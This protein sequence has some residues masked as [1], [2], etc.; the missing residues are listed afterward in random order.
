MALYVLAFTDSD[1]GTWTSAGRRFQTV[2][3]GAVYAVCERRSAVP[4]L[5]DDALRAQHQAVIEIADRS[6]A[7]L[8]ARFGALIDERELV[9]WTRDHETELRRGLDDVRDRVQMTLRIVGRQARPSS[10][11]ATITSGRAYLESRRRAME[12]ELAPAVRELLDK[13]R[14]LVAR[15][16]VE[17]GQGGLLATVYHLISRGDLASYRCIVEGAPADTIV[18]GPWPPFAFTPPL[19]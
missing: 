11:P 14:P 16:R 9:K 18:S 10:E 13:L 3:L 2:K 5:T 12:P 1:L 15:E 6:R 4:D 17:A 8:P 7:T 19:W